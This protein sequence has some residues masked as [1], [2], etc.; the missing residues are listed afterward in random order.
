VQLD[1][2]ASSS[3]IATAFDAECAAARQ[4]EAATL[5][6]PTKSCAPP[7]IGATNGGT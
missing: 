1:A 3:V 5:A 2:Q 6:M 4:A 7:R